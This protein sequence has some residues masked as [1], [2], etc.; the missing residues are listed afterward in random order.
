MA[1]RLLA[2]L[3][4]ARC[5][6]ASRFVNEDVFVMMGCPAGAWLPARTLMDALTF[7]LAQWAVLM[8]D[9]RWCQLQ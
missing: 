6:V 2:L 7:M 5:D 1:A 8:C 9:N 4:R 3:A